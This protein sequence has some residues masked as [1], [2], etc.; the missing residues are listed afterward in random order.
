LWATN[1]YATSNPRIRNLKDEIP[2]A[3]LDELDEIKMVRIGGK[4]EQTP[5][6]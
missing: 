4:A 5:N 3:V 6:G 2:D 1:L